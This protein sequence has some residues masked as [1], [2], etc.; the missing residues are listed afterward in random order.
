MNTIIKLPAQER[1]ILDCVARLEQEI[2]RLS[3]T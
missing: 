3:F 2:N 1:E